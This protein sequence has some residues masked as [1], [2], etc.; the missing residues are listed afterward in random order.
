MLDL[1][2]KLL[3][4]VNP[5]SVVIACRFPFPNLQPSHTIDSGVDTVWVYKNFK[6]PS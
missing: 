2:K 1:E 6:N 5:Q 3:T 4:E